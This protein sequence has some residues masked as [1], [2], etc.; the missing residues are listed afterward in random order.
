MEIIDK[1]RQS[2]KTL[3][4]LNHIK[5]DP[6]TVLLVANEVQARAARDRL[7]FDKG[8]TRA[9]AVTRVFSVASFLGGGRVN[10]L[11]K[12]AVLVIDELDAVLYSVL[13]REVKVVTST[14]D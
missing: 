5:Y 7:V 10:E 12:D 14:G 9:A 11:P 1:P 3:E 2:G 8:M 13:K 6:R 4:A